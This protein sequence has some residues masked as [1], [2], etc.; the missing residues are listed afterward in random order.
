MLYGR[1]HWCWEIGSSYVFCLQER[2]VCCASDIL[3]HSKQAWYSYAF[4]FV[5]HFFS[6]S[7]TDTDVCRRILFLQNGNKLSLVLELC[8]TSMHKES[9]VHVKDRSVIT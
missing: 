9:L 8:V 3:C 1:L 5:I 4:C 2:D 7:L 6:C